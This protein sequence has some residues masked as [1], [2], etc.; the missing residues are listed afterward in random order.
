MALTTVCVGVWMCERGE[1]WKGIVGKCLWMFVVTCVLVNPA[2]NIKVASNPTLMTC[3]G[4]GPSSS[5]CDD[6]SL[7]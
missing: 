6:L 4:R 3:Q 1:T 2:L 5:C 7:M